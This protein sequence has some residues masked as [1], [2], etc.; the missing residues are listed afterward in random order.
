MTRR[1]LISLWAIAGVAALLLR[2]VIALTPLAYDALRHHQL[3]PPQ[4]ALLV[5]W[6]AFNAYAEGVVGFHQKFAPR[7][8]RRALELGE[9]PSVLRVLLGAPYAIGFFAAPRRTLVTAWSVLAIIVALVVSVR[10]LDQPWRGIVDAGVVVGLAIG[11][12]SV[13]YRF[14]RELRSRGGA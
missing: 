11:L 8:V 2:A 3:A 5:G 12:A 10:F 1:N 13:V 7:V 9:R 14:A 6:V 4:W